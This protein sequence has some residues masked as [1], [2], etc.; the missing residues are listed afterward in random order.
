MLL[1]SDLDVQQTHLWTVESKGV[2]TVSRQILKIM[3]LVSKA[4]D[5][6]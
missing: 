4:D 6:N 2:L 3:V 5:L 1:K